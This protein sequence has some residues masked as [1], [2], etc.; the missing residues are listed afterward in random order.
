MLNYVSN[1]IRVKVDGSYLNQERLAFTHKI[2][3]NVYIVYEIN[4]WLHT[5][6][7]E[8]EL[9]NSL[10]GTSKLTTNTTDFEKNEYPGYGI[11]FD[12][13]GSFS[14]SDSSGFGKNVIIFGADMSSHILIIRKICL[15]FL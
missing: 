5:V 13:R 15:N 6:G 2:V 14:L 1:K 11:W 12:A 10:F 8:F 9:G 3:I 4:L 7:R